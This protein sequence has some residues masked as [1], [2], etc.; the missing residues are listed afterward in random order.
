MNFEGVPLEIIQEVFSWCDIHTVL[1]RLSLVSRQF[2]QV[3]RRKQ[4]WIV[5]L[6]ALAARGMLD[7]APEEDLGQLSRHQLILKVKYI[8][9]GP[10]SWGPSSVKPLLRGQETPITLQVPTSDLPVYVQLLQG[11][12]FLLVLVHM[13]GHG[14]WQPQLVDVYER[15]VV[16]TV[17][18]VQEPDPIPTLVVVSADGDTATIALLSSTDAGQTHFRLSEYSCKTQKITEKLTVVLSGLLPTSQNLKSFVAR[19]Q[20]RRFAV[21]KLPAPR[22]VSVFVEEWRSFGSQFIEIQHTVSGHY[23]I[24]ASFSLRFLSIEG[25]LRLDV[26][27]MDSLSWTAFADAYDGPGSLV[28]HGLLPASARPT[29][30]HRPAPSTP[31]VGQQLL[32][33]FTQSV[34]TTRLATILL[35]TYLDPLHHD[36]HYIRIK[37]VC[38][39]LGGYDTA[40][41]VARRVFGH[42]C[43]STDARLPWRFEF[44]LGPVGSGGSRRMALSMPRPSW[45]GDYTPTVM[46]S[47]LEESFSR[48]SI[49][50]GALV[51]S[52]ISRHVGGSEPAGAYLFSPRKVAT[53]PFMLPNESVCAIGKYNGGVVCSSTRQNADYAELKLRVIRRRLGSENRPQLSIMLSCTIGSFSSQIKWCRAPLNSSFWT[54]GILGRPN[55]FPA[56][57][58]RMSTSRSSA[59]RLYDTQLAAA[60]PV[61][62]NAQ[63]EE[64]YDAA[65][66]V[67]P[68]RRPRMG[69]ASDAELHR[70][71]TYMFPR[72]SLSPGGPEK[73]SPATALTPNDSDSPG[74]AESPSSTFAPSLL[75]PNR[76]KPMMFPA[77]TAGM[78]RTRTPWYRRPW[79][80]FTAV[81]V[82]ALIG[83][84]IGAAVG[85]TLSK[86]RQQSESTNSSD[87]VA[88]Q[89][90]ASA[91]I[92]F[93]GPSS[94]AGPGATSLSG[95][96]IVGVGSL[97]D[98]SSTEFVGDGTVSLTIAP[99]SGATSLAARRKRRAHRRKAARPQLSS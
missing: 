39:P 82:L 52:R 68:I 56:S 72:A 22:V 44:T 53:A 71:D 61:P 6:R 16:W 60:A 4:L 94:V 26:Y 54:V 19:G 21:L 48:Y 3:A 2:R 45:I 77:D 90:Q 42:Q 40:F 5:L 31:V 57:R 69:T 8:A 55:L 32:P 13:D 33:V 89:G 29:R 20:Y 58:A 62:T 10:R 78:D 66:L 83:V 17:Q 96:A 36:R 73:S 46:E 30:W 75:S 63:L 76:P 34:P 95:N 51:D 37:T 74:S 59:S 47:A 67:L 87:G 93:P 18:T 84:V 43:P 97:A 38:E 24:V 27:P 88:E 12:R 15:R 7:L 1:C 41:E 50:S 28:G 91:S 99:I 64:G 85:E 80:V 70:L 35:S 11:G 49:C 79:V 14:Q 92:S 9:H 65:P 25:T 23:L 98:A 86:R 81:G